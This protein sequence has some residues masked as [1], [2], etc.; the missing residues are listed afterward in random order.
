M[1][2]N[3]SAPS[4]E[5]ADSIFNRIQKIWNNHVV[6][7]R[8]KP[9]LDTMSI[10]DL[11]NNFKIVEQEVKGTA[12][13]NSSS[14]NM[15]FVSSPST[16][17]VHTAY[18]VS[19]ASTQ[20]STASTQL[21]LLS[22]RAKRFFQ[23]TGN[24]ITINGSDTSGF[25]K[26]KVECYN[27]H[28]IRHFA[29]ECRGLRNQ[30]SRNRYPD[31]SRRT[32]HVEETPPKAMVAIDR[33]G[34]DWSYMAEDEVPTN[35]ALMAFSDYKSCEIES[36]NASEDIPNEL[37]EYP[38]A[39]LVKDRMSDNKDCSVESPVVI[40][41]KTVAPTIA[42]VEV[43][44]P[45]QQEKLV[46][47]TVRAEM[48]RRKAVNTARP[49]PAVVN[50][51]RANQVNAVKALACWVWRP[52]KPNGTSITL[53]RHNY[54]DKTCPIS[55]ILRNSM[56]DMLPLN[57]EQMVAELL[58]TL[59]ESM[60]WHRRL[61]HINFKNIN[62]L[63]K[64][65]LVRGLPSKLFENDQT[66]VA[67]L[68]GKQNKASCIRREFSVAR[69]PQQ[70]SVAE[71]RNRTLIEAA[72]TM[73]A[74]SK[75][76]ITF[77]AEAVNTACYVPN[78]A[79]V[80]KPHK[81]TPYEL[82]RGRSPALS[83]MRPFGCHVTILNTLDNLGK[84]DRKADEGYFFRYSIN[85][86]AFKVYNIR[87]RRVEENLHI[88]FLE[89]NPI[90]GGAG[91]E[92]LFDIDMLTKLM[93]YVLVVAGTK[94]ND[95]ADGSSLFD[96]SPKISDDVGS[97][98]S[99]DARKKHDVVSDKDNGA[100]N[101]LNSAFE[102]LNIVPDDLKMPGLETI[103]TYDDFEEKDDFTKLES[104]IHVSP[105]PTT[106]IHKNHPLKQV[107]GS[108]N[109]PV[110]TRS[111]LKPTN[112][113]GFISAVYEGKT[114][115]DLNTCLFTCFLLQIEPTRVAKALSD[116]TWV[117]AMQE[118][119]LQF[120]LQKGY[121]QEEGIYYDEVFAPVARIEAIR[122]FLAYASFMGFMVY[123]MDMKSDF[124]Y[125][126]IKEEVYVCQPLGFED[127]DHPNKV[128]KV[129]YF[130]DIIFG[131]TNK[132]LCVEFER[133]M[134]D[135]F[136][137]SSIGE[138][139]FFLGLQV[140]QKEDGIFISQDK[141]VAEVL[142]K[143]NFLDVKSASTPVDME[144]TLVK[145]VD[146]DDV[147]V[148]LYRSMIR[149]LMYL[150]ASRPDIIDSPFELVAYTDSDYVRASLD[151]KFTTRGCQ[152]LGGRLISW[153][154]KKQTMV[155]IFTTE[156]E[157][158][159]TASCCGQT[160]TVRTVDNEEQEITTIVDGKEFTVTEA[161]VRRHL[162][163]ADADGISVLPTTEIYDQ[164][165]LMG[166]LAIQA[167]E[168]EGSGHPSEPQP[169]PSTAQHTN[170]EPIPNVAPSSNQKTQT[171]RAATTAASLNAEQ[172]SGTINRTQ[173]TAMPNVPLPQGISSN[174]PPLSRG[175]TLG[176]G[177][178]SIELIKELMKTYTKL[179]ERVLALEESK[180]AQDLV[181][182]RLKLRVKK[183]E[184]KN[185]K[186]RTPHPLKMRLFKVRIESSTDEN[187][188]ED[189]RSKQE[190]SIIEEINQDAGT[191]TRR[192]R[193]VT[194]SNG[195]ISTTSRLIST[196]KESVSTAG[197]SMPVSTAGMVQEIH[198]NILSPVAVKDKGK[199][200]ME[201]FEDEQTKR[202]KLQQEQDRPGY[203]A[204]VRL[205]V[206][207]DEEERQR[208]ARRLQAEERNKYSEVDKVIM[209]IDLINQRK[210]YLAAQKAEAKRNKP[211]TQAQQR[212]YM[213][214][215]FKNIGSYT[216]NQLKKLSFDEIKKL[217]ETT[218]KIVNTFVPME[219]KVRGRASELA[220][221]SS[222]AIIT[223]SA[224]VG[225]SKR[226]A[227]AKIHYEHSK[228]QKIN[229]AS[230]SVQEQP[231]K[232]KI[233]LSQEDL[234]QMMMVVP[235]EEDN[236]EALQRYMHDP[237]TWRLYDTCGLH[238]VS[239]D[240]GMDIFMLVEKEYPLS[241]GIL[242]LMLVNKLLV[243]QH[244]EMANEL[245]KKIFIQESRP[246]H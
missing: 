3:F 72:R 239:T 114:H 86:K 195:G 150:T 111:K 148:H 220:A 67:C 165:S 222:Q 137:M 35:M 178:D 169:P 154:C 237:L 176:S 95:F 232:E 208:M 188:D 106:R 109:T 120:K 63:V 186:A 68:K 163:L 246:K 4:T 215:Y 213:S 149:S 65:N 223:D 102:N 219:T 17:E 77:W 79:L 90:V 166:M 174:D 243:D 230:G 126:R 121:T 153:Q 143:F 87:T 58:A 70:N 206:E 110:Q 145:D 119:L 44:R 161:S 196:T 141:Y 172:A 98:S 83:F 13:S 97:P 18:G 51:V 16:N 226:V 224:K 32:V 66:C 23:K 69:T 147:D 12:S 198:L 193:A 22:M 59:D 192:K 91:P 233:K 64:D 240:K 146:G 15:A 94:S 231:D 130:D 160:A 218:M 139:T 92:W 170:E 157:Y 42:K 132:E 159:A 173:S 133:L 191:Y 199:G 48:Y 26:S 205:Q 238:H 179:S 2:K 227:E 118:E 201:E 155:A 116:P 82:F 40:E 107:I 41:K 211:M 93:N 183:L 24:K 138:L 73:L 62:K 53:K 209:L 108:L 197:A 10:D 84:F 80:V 140:K 135:K 113:Q 99:G 221:R 158:V 234:Q 125:E 168:G 242:T 177:E 151:R 228:R 104:L 117:E 235:M 54:I 194:I 180:T 55:Q 96:S 144:K 189:D 28:K 6:A 47:K 124:L 33:V 21:A 50:A 88:K 128:Y 56:E 134:K 182:T 89:N 100:S 45:K 245:L 78:R 46:R 27:C 81:K 8:N 71:R 167:K 212:A 236:I 156:A 31:S 136:K 181:I 39:P 103:E 1:Y 152:F 185:K 171:P 60:L 123:Q 184:K 127:P 129:V 207:L 204:V 225:S 229:K 43:V 202:T 25:D 20:S 19:N 57:E 216:L 49:S 122:L 75:L 190:R 142:R 105:T 11:Y 29:R 38:V 14:Q 175:H 85:S 112:E 30:D 37:K 164:L 241:K 9:D 210:R 52:T 61:G 200:K 5:S 187:L 131:S 244:S 76:P 115:E 217:F 101:E 7:W 36:K 34:F 203:E 74:D 214:T 162:Q